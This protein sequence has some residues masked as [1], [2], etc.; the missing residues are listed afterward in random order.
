MVGGGEEK[1]KGKTSRAVSQVRSGQRKGGKEGG[2]SLAGV[3]G[4]R[5]RGAV[6]E[7]VRSRACWLALAC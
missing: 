5:E 1:E 7:K 6:A 4:G 3:G 2:T